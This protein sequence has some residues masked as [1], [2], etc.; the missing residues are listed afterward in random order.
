MLKKIG[1]VVVGCCGLVVPIAIAACSSSS[2]SPPPVYDSGTPLDSTVADTG[3]GGPDST[4]GDGPSNDAPASDGPG[5]DGGSMDGWIDVQ[6]PMPT[7]EC[8]SLA[9][10]KCS[11][12]AVCNPSALQVDFGG[13]QTACVSAIATLCTVFENAQGSAYTMTQIQACTTAIK[14]ITTCVN[15]PTPGGPC[16]FAGPAEG[17]APCGVGPQCASQMC[18]T[19]GRACGTCTSVAGAG[20]DCAGTSGATCDVGLVCDL[21]THK[22]STIV[23]DG[24]MCDMTHACAGGFGCVTTGVRDAGPMPGKCQPLGTAVGTACAR[25]NIGTPACW[26]QTGLFCSAAGQCTQYTYVG[27]GMQ[28][29]EMDGGAAYNVCSNASKCIGADGGATFG[30]GMCVPSLPSGAPCT[31]GQEPGCTLPEVC[32]APAG[33]RSGNCTL[34]NETNCP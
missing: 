2:M 15:V 9:M 17:G 25:F 16:Q 33:T 27:A 32:V 10:A 6:M 29:G 22:C 23:G 18:A 12:D 34:P 7:A 4:S 20:Q 28:C 19:G 31:L 21:A 8:T 26:D 24:G 30:P 14:S 1:W 3:G 13:S 11:Q 5:G